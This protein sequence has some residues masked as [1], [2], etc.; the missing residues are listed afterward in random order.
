MHHA[1]HFFVLGGMAFLAS[2]YR[3]GQL[4]P[5]YVERF[6]PLALYHPLLT[7]WALMNFIYLAVFFVGARPEHTIDRIVRDA[8]GL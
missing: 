4:I 2:W 1:Q 5:L 7:L 3:A 6:P 8:Y